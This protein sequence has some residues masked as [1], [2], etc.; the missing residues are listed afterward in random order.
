MGQQLAGEA[1]AE[2]FFAADSHRWQRV[3][4][5]GETESVPHD[6]HGLDA[7]GSGLD[8]QRQGPGPRRQDCG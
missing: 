2:R 1:E 3:G 4:L 6:L 5:V 7:F 8:V